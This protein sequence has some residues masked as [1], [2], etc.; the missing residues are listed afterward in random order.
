M[1]AAHKLKLMDCR[2]SNATVDGKNDRIKG[3]LNVNKLP[4]IN[5]IIDGER[6]A[7][8]VPSARIVHSVENIS[9]YKN[10]ISTNQ[11]V[12]SNLSKEVIGFSSR[13]DI[14]S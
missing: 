4:E 5:V 2:R 7:D 13:R 3:F 10:T 6:A 8:S 9:P 11:T 1:T 12:Q 14:V